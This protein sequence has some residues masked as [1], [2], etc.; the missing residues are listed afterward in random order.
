MDV[1]YINL[2]IQCKTMSIN[3]LIQNMVTQILWRIC[4]ELNNKYSCKDY[5]D[6]DGNDYDDDSGTNAVCNIFIN[7]SNE[8]YSIEIYFIP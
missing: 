8:K 5:A 6:D 7:A 4:D 3:Q 1:Y 2:Q